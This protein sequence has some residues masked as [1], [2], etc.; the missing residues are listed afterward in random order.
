GSASAPNWTKEQ[1]QSRAY[2]FLRD[3]KSIDLSR[4]K[5]VEAESKKLPSRTDHSFVW[6]EAQA[7]NP[8][9]PGAEAAHVRISLAV[10]GDEVSGYRI[11]IHLPEDWVR[12][13]NES[14]LS[15]TAQTD[16]V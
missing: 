12:K 13:Q 10:Q 9:P 1:A 8:S 7:L 4:W 6:E 5:L 11:F 16:L 3:S 2:A 15:N 14:T